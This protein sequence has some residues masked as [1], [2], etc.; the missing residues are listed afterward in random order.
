MPSLEIYRKLHDGTT[1]Q[2]RKRQSDKIMD[3]TWWN[4]IQSRVAYLYDYY[5]D[6]YKMQLDDLDSSNDPKKIPIDIKFVQ[7]SSQTYEKDYVTYHL[8]LR[9]EQECNVEYYNELFQQRYNAT[10]PIG[11]Y[12]DIPDE[13]GKY[14]KWLVVD[15]ANY[16]VTQFPTFE[17][18][19][20]DK[21]FQ[22]IVDRKKYEIAG[23]L[24]SQ[25]SYN[26]GVWRDYHIETIEDQ[27]KFCVPINRDTE[28]IYYNL[29]MIIDT[30]VLSE[31]RTWK[32]T[33]INRIAP[34]GIIRATLAQTHFN[35]NTDY[36]EIGEDGNV[37]GMWADYYVE[38]T[39]AEPTDAI[40]PQNNNIIATINYAGNS[41]IRLNG[42]YKK[43]T[44]NFTKGDEPIDFMFGQWQYFVDNIDVSDLIT[45]SSTELEENEIKFKI[46]SK[47]L[48]YG[49][50][51]LVV[52]YIVNDDIQ[53]SL[54]LGITNF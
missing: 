6:D 37:I 31:P 2:E 17:I 3:F 8:Q 25:S 30:G 26:S 1:G 36:I 13:Q 32:I 10:F 53:A 24:R 14:N 9:P 51:T 49:G 54:E 39:T 15:K 22:Y 34:N 38:N 44:V 4:D 5:H 16:N 48:T 35:P 27:Q 23:V 11:L 46:S 47:D 40:Q 28:K 43:L 33:K 19:R 45:Y 12:I 18:L 21:V 7:S 29:R 50:K 20:C 42:G 52:K 41:T